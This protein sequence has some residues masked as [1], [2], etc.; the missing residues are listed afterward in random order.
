[1]GIN[2]VW[3]DERGEPLARC[4]A[5]YDDRL[6]RAV[7]PER[8]HCLQYIGPTDDATFNQAQVWRLVRELEEVAAGLG[9]LPEER[10]RQFRTVLEFVRGCDE[11]HTYVRFIGD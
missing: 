7:P 5:I 10:Q 3:Q 1:M 4:E 2:V 9:H 11:L 8:S 6:G